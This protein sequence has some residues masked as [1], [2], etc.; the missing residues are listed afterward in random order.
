MALHG[1]ARQRPVT[2]WLCSR[3]AG[4]RMRV[5]PRAAHPSVGAV[6]VLVT[7]SH[8]WTYARRLAPGR[9]PWVWCLLACRGAGPAVPTNSA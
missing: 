8:A 7:L 6:R 5:A 4:Q 1:R 2:A 3:G 9:G